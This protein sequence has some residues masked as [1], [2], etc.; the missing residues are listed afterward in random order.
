MEV[1]N[2]VNVNVN[3]TGFS[4]GIDGLTGEGIGIV[5]LKGKEIN[6]FI[7]DVQ[8]LKRGMAKVEFN[9]NDYAIY[10]KTIPQDG[11]QKLTFSHTQEV[12]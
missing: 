3:V 9:V 1:I 12:E 2:V 10:S 5:M 8:S 4:R 7:G 11:I 6:F